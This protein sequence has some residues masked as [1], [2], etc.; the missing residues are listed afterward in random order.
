MKGLDQQADITTPQE[1]VL[2]HKVMKCPDQLAYITTW[3]EVTLVIY[4][5]EVYEEH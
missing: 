2:V 3:Q 1:V 4:L 5:L